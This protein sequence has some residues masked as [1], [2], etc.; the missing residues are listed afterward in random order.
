MDASYRDFVREVRRYRLGT[1]LRACAETGALLVQERHGR[2]RLAA[3]NYV[4]PFAVAAVAGAALDAANEHRRALADRAVVARLC[5]AFSE[6]DDPDLGDGPDAPLRGLLSRLAYQQLGFGGSFHDEAGRSIGLLLD[7]AARVTG[8]P[9]P[10]EW[11]RLL[12]VPL[13]TYMRVVFAM[14]VATVQNPAAV[15][16]A[17][18]LRNDVAPIF[19]PAQ[20]DDAMAVVDRWLASTPQ[21]HRAWARTRAVPGHELWSPNPLQHRPLV[22]V[23][24]ELIAPVPDWVLGRMSPSGLW[25]TGLDAFGSRFTDAVGT[26]FESYVGEHLALIAAATV[27]PEV[28]YGTPE[29][30]TV[31]WFVVTDEAVVLVEVKAARPVLATRIGSDD[32]DRHVLRRIGQARD[33]I[34]RTA[35]M[36]AEGHPALAHIPAD[37]PV[38]GLVVTLEPFHLVDT[39]LFDDVLPATTT[40]GATAS[41]HDV[42]TVCAVLADRLDAGQLLLDALTAQPPAPP[43]LRRSVDGLPSRRNPLLDRWWRRWGL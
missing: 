26:A 43:S 10:E 1:V 4:T 13:E 30:R 31:D 35:A 7:H 8:G 20:P 29:R 18:L 40:A 12:G 22:A 3:P 2:A 39:F 21:E 34:D 24:D 27:H 16:R 41:A 32:G 42:E 38:R 28:V 15:T 33:Q 19:A 5:G 36:L 23:G 17:L 11:E 25:F 14:F 6:L 9:S 37:R